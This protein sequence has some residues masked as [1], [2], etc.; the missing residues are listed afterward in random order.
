MGVTSPRSESGTRSLEGE[1]RAAIAAA[2]VGW[3]L[4]AL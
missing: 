3:T 1:D 4:V 2:G